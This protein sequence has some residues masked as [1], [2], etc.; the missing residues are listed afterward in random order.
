MDSKFFV[1]LEFEV[2]GT[3]L[4]PKPISAHDQPF[5]SACTPTQASK[6]F[7]VFESEITYWEKTLSHISETIEI[8]LQVPPGVALFRSSANW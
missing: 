4:Y 2:A 6:F 7:V 8:I 1:V 3:K 5:C